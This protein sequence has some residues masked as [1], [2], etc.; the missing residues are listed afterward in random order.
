MG[1]RALL[2]I[3]AIVLFILST[4]ADDGNLGALGLACFAG[5]FLTEDLGFASMRIGGPADRHRA[6]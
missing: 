6:P 5:A 2:L 3:A 1:L 4:L